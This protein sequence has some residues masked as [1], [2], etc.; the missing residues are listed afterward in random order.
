MTFRTLFLFSLLSLPLAFAQAEDR[1]VPPTHPDVAYGEHDKQGF[2]L[3]LVP[4][5]EEPTPLV[6]YIHGGGFRG[7]DKS[8]VKKGV[9]EGYLKRGIAFAS[10]NYRLSDSGAYPIMMHDAARGLQTIRYH[11][12]EWNIDPQ[13]IICYGGSAGAGISLWLAFHDDL[14]DPNSDDPIARQSTRIHAAGTSDGQSTYNMHTFRE[15]FG[16]PDLP[17]HSALPPLYGVELDADLNDPKVTKQMQDVSSIT[18]LSPDDEVEVYMTYRRPNTK[19]TLETS[20]S[21][22]V[23]HPLLGLKLKEAMHKLDLK[24]Y[25]TAPDIKEEND[26]YGSLTNFLVAKANEKPE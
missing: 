18:H 9:A 6:I 19:V 5:A 14:A 17:I 24:C 12:K 26:P 3:W 20:K 25:V 13:R 23:H 2:D 15:W 21:D 8:T 22:W 4:D 16:V 10:M 11:A 1:D 7:G